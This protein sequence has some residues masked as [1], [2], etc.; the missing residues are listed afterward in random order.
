MKNSITKLLSM[1][2][3]KIFSTSATTCDDSEFHQ[4]F[5]EVKMNSNGVEINSGSSA[6]LKGTC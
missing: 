6:Y 2:A 1:G 4:Y 5:T 3:L